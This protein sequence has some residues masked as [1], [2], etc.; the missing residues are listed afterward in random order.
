[1][2]CSIEELTNSR[3][4]WPIGHPENEDFA[5]CGNDA[6]GEDSPYCEFHTKKAYRTDYVSRAEK[7]KLKKAA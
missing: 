7:E 5:F 1:M 6:H 2:T 4:K 3:C